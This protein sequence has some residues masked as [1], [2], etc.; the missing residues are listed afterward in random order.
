MSDFLEIDVFRLGDIDKI[1]AIAAISQTVAALLSLFALLLSI[2]VYSRQQHLNRWQL[3]LAREDHIIAWARTCLMLMAEVEEHVRAHVSVGGELL[4][5]EEFISFR[6][7]L[8]AQIDEGRLYFP[9]IKDPVKGAKKDT[10][11]RGHRQKIL[12][13]LVAFYDSLDAM[14]ERP[15]TWTDSN[16]AADLN[17]LRR[18]FISCTQATIDPDTFN[19]V[20][21]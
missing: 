13:V 15:G 19:R 4:S 10:A 18:A 12:D 20:R 21:A 14:Q 9:N 8:S 5:R 2:W 16:A 3:R 11:F 1:N 7:R 6:G 17:S